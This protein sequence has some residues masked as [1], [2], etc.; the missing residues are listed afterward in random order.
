MKR[1]LSHPLVALGLGLCLRLYLVL[2][3]PAVSGDTP[4]YEELA[5]NWIKHGSYAVSLN[6]VITPVDVRMPGYS[7]L[8][9]AIYAITGRTGEAARLPVMVTQIAADLVCSLVVAAIASSLVKVAAGPGPSKRAFKIALWLA[10]LCPFTAGYTSAILTESLAT[11]FSAIS[12]YFLVRLA[13]SAAELFRP[14]DR[15]RASWDKTPANWAALFGLAVGVTTL[16]RPESPLL[17]VVAWLSLGVG[18]VTHGYIA[19]WIKLVLLSGALCFAALLPWTVRNTVTLHELQPLA[20]K[21][22][23]LPSER[24]PTGFMAW[25]RTWLYRMSECYAVTWKLNEENIN[26]D[27]IPSRAFDSEAEKKQV[28]A[29]IERHNKDNNLSEGADAEFGAIARRRTAR[30]PLRTYLFVPLQ[31]VLTIW[32]TPRIELLPFNGTVFPLAEEWE[33]DRADLVVT[34]FFFFLN[35]FYLLAAIWGAV[36]LWRWNPGARLALFAIV[37]YILIRTAFLTTVEAPEPRYVLVCFPA[38]LALVAVAFFKRQ[39]TTSS[40]RPPA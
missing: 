7:A 8:L 10:A 29:L 34:L 22:A 15:L 31:R 6:G 19:R 39:A 25:E 20:P 1:V 35:I 40:V 23:T 9:A 14:T 4:L 11:L 3:F 24:P 18:F 12:I 16:F 32:F 30:R 13:E 17:P 36:K 37:A 21:D 26:L 28:A 5:T 27:D 33:N 2:K 38:I